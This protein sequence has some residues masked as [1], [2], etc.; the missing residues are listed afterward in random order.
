MIVD[1]KK[2]IL[3]VIVFATLI[4]TIGLIQNEDMKDPYSEG[5]HGDYSI[6]CENGFKYMYKHR[7]AILL[8]NEDG[9]PMKCNK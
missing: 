9:T 2:I 1:I 8:L 3:A 6:K 7:G 4:L 5:M